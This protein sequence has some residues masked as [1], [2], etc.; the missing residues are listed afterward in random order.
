MCSDVPQVG[1]KANT[2]AQLEAE[3]NIQY[4]GRNR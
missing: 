1:A 3:P 2:A 4:L